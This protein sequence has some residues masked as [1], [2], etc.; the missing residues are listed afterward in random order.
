MWDDVF[1]VATSV[2]S[3]P[4]SSYSVHLFTM[5]TVYQAT[6]SAPVNIACIK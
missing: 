4:I 2:V 3:D 1:E 5:T 6:A